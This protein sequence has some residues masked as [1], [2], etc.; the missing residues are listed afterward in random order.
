MFLVS[1]DYG[2]FKGVMTH[3]DLLDL[4]LTELKEDC[5][6]NRDDIDILKYCLDEFEFMIKNDY[7]DDKYLCEA[8]KGY[9]WY[10]QDLTDM[11]RNLNNFREFLKNKNDLMDEE[12]VQKIDEVLKILE[13][14]MK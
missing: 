4:C 11:Q 13:S 5:L 8:L 12:K 1:D 3:K 9:G 7:I 2:T 14:E 6:N 10:I